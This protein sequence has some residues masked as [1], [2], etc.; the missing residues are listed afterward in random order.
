MR[1]ETLRDFPSYL[2]SSRGCKPGTDLVRPQRESSGCAT[3]TVELHP[4]PSFFDETFAEIPPFY[5]ILEA[6]FKGG[7]SK[8]G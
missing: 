6:G 1:R 3:E 5:Q 7:R 4:L 2:C 8:K